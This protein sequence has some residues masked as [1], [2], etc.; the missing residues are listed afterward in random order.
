MLTVRAATSED[1]HYVGTRLRAEDAA[2]VLLFG[3]DGESAIAF[4]LDRSIV[5]ECLLVDG[6]PA[7]VF[8]I[9]IDDMIGGTGCPWMLTTPAVERCQLAFARATRRLCARCFEM[10]PRLENLIDARYT[11]AIKWLQWLGF[12][13]EPEQAGVRRFWMEA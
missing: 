9:A 6:E 1:A 2:E 7:A 10:V 12:T 4:S 13:V 5:S 11:R 8:G 3:L